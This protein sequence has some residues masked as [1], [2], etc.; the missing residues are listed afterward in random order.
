MFCSWRLLLRTLRTLLV[1]IFHGK[2]NG[3]ALAK[4]EDK[5]MLKMMLCA[6]IGSLR[7]KVLSACAW[8]RSFVEQSTV[9]LSALSVLFCSFVRLRSRAACTEPR[10]VTYG[11]QERRPHSKI[12]PKARST[13]SR[14]AT[15]TPLENT[16]Q[17]EINRFA[18]CDW[19]P[20]PR[21]V[22]HPSALRS[23]EH[24]RG[25]VAK[26]LAMAEA[27]PGGTQS[28]NYEQ[29]LCPAVRVNA[30]AARAALWRR[31]DKI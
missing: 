5:L 2:R 9:R 16:P 22:A 10:G 25:W 26:I 17:G 3:P 14:S 24:L 20:N 21:K 18:V 15:C 12:R 28:L 19:V 13:G 7:N 29:V 30:I 6:L 27:Q 23:L 4:K 11:D 1:V 31:D 8:R